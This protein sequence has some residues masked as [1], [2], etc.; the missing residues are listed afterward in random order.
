MRFK[1]DRRTV[2]SG[3][4]D[5]FLQKI[6]V[7]TERPKIA[8]GQAVHKQRIKLESLWKF[9]FESVEMRGRVEAGVWDVSTAGGNFRDIVE[10]MIN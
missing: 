4:L 3:E 2:S 8:P 10:T 9:P 6:D 1:C 7:V 5:G